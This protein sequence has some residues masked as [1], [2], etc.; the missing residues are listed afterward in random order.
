LATALTEDGRHRE[1]INICE[2]ALVFGLSDGTKGGFEGRIK[3]IRK[4]VVH[5]L[6]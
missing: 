5:K 6:P 4:K 3:R 1:A 2:A